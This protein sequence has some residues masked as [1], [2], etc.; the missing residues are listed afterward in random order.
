MQGHAA[1]AMGAKKHQANLAIKHGE[2]FAELLA[3]SIERGRSE[4]YGL[5]DYQADAAR[6][7][8]GDL[9]NALLGLAGESGEFI[10]LMKKHLFHGHPV[11]R[12][13]A[14]KELGDLLWYVADLAT[15]LDL[16]LQ[17]IALVNIAK[18]RE[19]YP[20]GFT[21]EASIARVDQGGE[22]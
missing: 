4:V 21:S 16:D 14:G 19:R 2:L 9:T 12:V 10:D 6:T 18:L 7:T 20:D 8:Q 17:G 15:C 13:K 5:N 3:A 22:A 11:D 1:K